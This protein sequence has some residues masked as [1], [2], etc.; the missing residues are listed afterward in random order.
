M[1]RGDRVKYLR[2]RKG[3]THEELAELLAVSVSQIWRY[4][5]DKIDP[6]SDVVA[7]LARLFGVTTDYLVGLSDEPTPP[8]AG[9]L[10]E[11]E[12]KIVSA[13]RHGEPMEAIRMIADDER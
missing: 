12:R 7:R 6:S 10:S 2:N 13:L 3:Y 4:E 11:K 9:E 1:L 8:I 5:A